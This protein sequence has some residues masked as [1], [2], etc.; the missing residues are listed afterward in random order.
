MIGSIRN[1]RKTLFSEDHLTINLSSISF[2]NGQKKASYLSFY[3][4]NNTFIVPNNITSWV[5]A[6]K[7]ILTLRT[8]TGRSKSSELAWKLSQKMTEFYLFRII[9]YCCLFLFFFSGNYCLIFYGIEGFIFQ[10]ST[11]EQS[12]KDL[13]AKKSPCLT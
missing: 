1:D 11:R 12:R 3:N 5:V 10:P 7:S 6:H 13:G 2:F 4:I 9:D 8:E